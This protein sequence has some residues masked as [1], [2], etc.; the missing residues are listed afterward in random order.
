[1]TRHRLNQWLLAILLSAPV[2]LFAQSTNGAVKAAIL[3]SN[4]VY[5]RVG[6]IGQDLPAEIQSA[7]QALAASNNIA[8][9]VVDL[10]F[11][12]G[13]DLDSAKAVESLLE[14]GKLPLAIL[15]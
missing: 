2:S 14:Q 3:E 8:G 6:V 1:M 10:R 13:D 4:V 15:V 12:G 5:L 9:T 11:A 7:Q